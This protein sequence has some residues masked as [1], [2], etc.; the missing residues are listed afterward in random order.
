MNTILVALYIVGFLSLSIM[1][2]RYARY[3]PWRR[4]PMGRAF[5]MMK[6]ALWAV[7]AHALIVR[8]FHDWAFKDE[9]RFALTTYAVGAIVY[10]TI[11]VIRYQ[12]GRIRRSETRERESQ[13][14]SA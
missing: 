14:S 11:V 10:Q 5:M 13:R 3:S 8:T 1:I 2:Y 7:L 4:S 9:L 12:G 6:T